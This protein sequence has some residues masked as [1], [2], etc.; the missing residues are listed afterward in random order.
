MG[1]F[2]WIAHLAETGNK[3]ELM[4]EVGPIAKATG[5]TCEEV[6]DGFINAHQEMRENKD[7]PAYAKLN[8][9]HDKI[10]KENENE[11]LV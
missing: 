7:N 10:K 5:K 9:I 11:S 2:S 3:K 8:E 1:K 4:E 6:A